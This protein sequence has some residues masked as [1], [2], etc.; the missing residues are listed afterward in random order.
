VSL[1]DPVAIAA[2]IERGELDVA[3]DA[4]GVTLD[5]A[6]AAKLVELGGKDYSWREVTLPRVLAYIAE[7]LRAPIGIV[8]DRVGANKVAHVLCV[9]FASGDGGERLAIDVSHRSRF[10]IATQWSEC[11]GWAKKLEKNRERADKWARAEGRFSIPIVRG[12]TSA[13]ASVQVSEESL[14][15]AI[16]AAPD[17]DGPRL[18]YADW[19]LER[20]DARGDFIRLQCELARADERSP[21]ALELYELVEPMRKA[22]WRLFAGELA[23]YASERSFHRGFVDEVRMPVGV[24]AKHGER[25]FSRYPIRGLVAAPTPDLRKLAAVPALRLVEELWLAEPTRELA[26]LAGARLDRLKTLTLKRCAQSE[27]DLTSLLA[28]I[29]APALES[30][31][32]DGCATGGQVFRALAR[33][34]RLGKLRRLRVA[35]PSMSDWGWASG[36]AALAAARPIAELEL[37]TWSGLRGDAIAPF[38]PRLRKLKLVDAWLGD[39]TGRD[40]APLLEELTHHDSG[41]TAAGVLRLVGPRLRFIDIGWSRWTPEDK[42]T[43]LRGLLALPADHPLRVVE[44]SYFDACDELTAVKKRFSSG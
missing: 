43:F 42:L 9:R 20:G 40:G 18:V 24:F 5:A 26:A 39:E 23:R 33:N 10:G 37:A 31:S 32:L 35:S 44:L 29:D 36:L 13:G 8:Y 30:V 4:L 2:A 14:L 17:D 21:R 25:L 27:E 28:S 12:A 1:A 6:A 15:A 38:V 19:L 11:Q 7:A 22:S 3:G 41:L 34:Q 16:V